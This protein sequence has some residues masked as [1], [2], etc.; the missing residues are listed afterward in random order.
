LTAEVIRDCLDSMKVARLAVLVGCASAVAAAPAALDVA[1]EVG[2]L[3]SPD[4]RVRD[5]AAEHIRAAL[6]ANPRAA[7][8]HD[9]A[10]WRARFAAVKRGWSHEQLEREL[11]ARSEGM[12]MSGGSET[13]LWRLDDYWMAV[14][15]FDRAGFR[16]LGAI[17]S[18]PRT[19]WAV[20][21]KDFTGRW[22]TYF[23]TGVMSQA[24][25]FDHGASVMSE[26]Y[27]PNGQLAY[28]QRYLAGTID[29][30]ELGYH[31]NGAKAYAG[32]HAAGNKVG[33]W[34]HWYPDGKLE[35][36]SDYDAAGELNGVSITYRPDGTKQ[37]LF[38]YVHG[39]ETGQA[40]WDEHGALEY[41]HG[42]TA[43]HVH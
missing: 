30:A 19:V 27:Y 25:Q 35:S 4:P 17:E 8:G 33:H 43:A 16:E 2:R 15:Y 22:V 34:T 14:T 9:V 31:Q 11:G 32:W 18:R 38:E 13:A 7:G 29:G 10:Y 12:V 41:A 39:K 28:R 24:I 23:V 42:T 26:A 36:E 6:A 1:A 37:V 5:A 20:P 40:A 21:P 3:A